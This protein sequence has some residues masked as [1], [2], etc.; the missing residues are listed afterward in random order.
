MR[1]REPLHARVSAPP[2]FKSRHE[3]M[4]D[5]NATAYYNARVADEWLSLRWVRVYVLGGQ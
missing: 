3:G 1:T 4:V 2:R 5:T